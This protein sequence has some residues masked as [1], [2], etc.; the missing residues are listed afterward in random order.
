MS[1]I[2]LSPSTAL[3]PVPAVMISS[4]D[5]IE[6]YNIMTASWTGLVCSR[7][8]MTYVSM[9]PATLSH[10]ILMEKKEFV[11]NLTPVELMETMDWVGRISGRDA[12][13]WEQKGLTP[14]AGTHVKAPL[15]QECP[16]NIECSVKQ[17]LELGSHFMFLAEIVA[18]HAD[19]CYVQNGRLALS[20]FT[21]VANV[22]ADYHLVGEAVAP[23]G[24]SKKSE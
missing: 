21:T 17:I 20:Q 1:K 3:A 19:E 2:L 13:K 23:M 7:P 6:N 4:G 9:R 14:I 15:I 10:G 18:V 12:N 11:I 22:G 8:P 5:S 24:F 16:V